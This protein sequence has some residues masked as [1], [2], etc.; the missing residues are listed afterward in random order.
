YVGD[1]QNHRVLIFPAPVLAGKAFSDEGTTGIGSS[2]TVSVS[3]NGTS[4]TL[5]ALTDNGSQYVIKNLFTTLTGGSL[6]SLYLSRGSGGA[7]TTLGSR[8]SMTGMT[9]YQ[10]DLIVPSDSGTVAI[11][12]SQLANAQNGAS[13]LPNPLPLNGGV[14][15]VKE[16]HGL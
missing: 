11:T 1:N 10:K 3:L 4:S 2:K 9:P 15:K 5:T 16:G 6:L 8:S 7:T 13:D 12:N 14:L